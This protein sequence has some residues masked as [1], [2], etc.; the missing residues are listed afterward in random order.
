[1]VGGLDA[2]SGT[3]GSGEAQ[4]PCTQRMRWNDIDQAVK[5]TKSGA[6][7]VTP[8][9]HGNSQRLECDQMVS[10]MRLNVGSPIRPCLVRLQALD[11]ERQ[12]ACQK[13]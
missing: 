2:F 4:G 12:A 13:L 8:F 1:M 11:P 3:D 9:E 7:I 10:E 5:R 6:N